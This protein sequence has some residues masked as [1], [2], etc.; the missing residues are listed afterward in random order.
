VIEGRVIAEDFAIRG[1][2]PWYYTSDTWS[3]MYTQF[4]LQRSASGGFQYF[5]SYLASLGR[6]S[7][8]RIIIKPSTTPRL[9]RW[10][11]ALEPVYLPLETGVGLKWDI[12]DW[13]DHS[14]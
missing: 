3:Q 7:T 14:T 1:R 13:V 2:W 10:Q 9:D 8:P 6:S 5:P 4:L 12:I 11:S